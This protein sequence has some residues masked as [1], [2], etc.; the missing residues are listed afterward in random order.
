MQA[1]PAAGRGRS[2][3]YALPLRRNSCESILRHLDI[4]PG[5]AAPLALGLGEADNMAEPTE[6]EELE[7]RP[8]VAFNAEMVKSYLAFARRS[9]KKNKTLGIAV[10]VIGVTMAILI[11]RYI[12][13]TYTCSTVLM[14]VETAVLDGDRGPRPLAGAEGLIMRHENLESLIKAINLMDK[15]Y[16]R[17]P[18]LLALKDRITQGLFGPMDKKTLMAVLVGTV[19]SRVVVELEPK[20]QRDT[21][22][23]TV[24]WSDPTTAAELA[25]ATKDGFLKIRHAA[26]ISAFQEKMAILDSHAKKLRDEVTTLAEQ[27]DADIAAKLAEAQRE[28]GVTPSQA[29]AKSRRIG[30]G[31]AKAP[32][33]M[34]AELPEIKARLAEGKQKLMAAEGERNN[35]MAS[36]QSKLDELKLRFTASHPQVITQEER[37]GLASNVSSELALLRSEV[38]DLQMRVNQRE[39]MLA[40]GQPAG[41]RL[42]LTAHEP[43][44][45]EMLPVDV[46]RVLDRE[47][48]DPALR[49]QLSGAIVRYGALRDE[50]RGA[51]MALDTAQAAFNHRYQIVIPVDP[52]SKPSKPNI[53]AIVGGG[54]F[55]SLLLGLLL[56]IAL[57]LRRGML[58]ETW[59]VHNFQLP[60]LAELRLPSHTED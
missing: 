18:P 16:V 42:G 39:A 30:L 26:E 10:A 44:G 51:K 48:G 40:T 1:V 4:Y 54:I 37:L 14:T 19:E 21:L 46:L 31:A 43:G 25:E 13:R 9:L 38:S 12:P 56:P 28:A 2:R 27:M 7:A 47:E 33:P 23:I 52:P 41:N 50:V 32:V 60:V 17:R 55:L 35:R 15:Y 57:E 59:Q 45:A 22:M 49:A 53:P 11:G 8:K 24:N 29:P 3:A 5:S 20:Q 6:D 34:D 36:E 58:V